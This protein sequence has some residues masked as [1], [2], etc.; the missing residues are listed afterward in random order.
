M[1]RHL[2]NLA[3]IGSLVLCLAMAALTARSCFT[4]D[5]LHWGTLSPSSVSGPCD[6]FISVDGLF[7]FNHLELSIGGQ[8]RLSADW[9]RSHGD[10]SFL[11]SFLAVLYNDP[12]PFIGFGGSLSEWHNG[13]CVVF[14]Q[15]LVF[16]AFAILPFFRQLGLLRQRRNRMHGR[17]PACGYDLRATPDRCP[18]CGRVQSKPPLQPSL[19]RLG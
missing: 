7:V 10:A 11:F 1:T 14:P 13:G 2:S 16:I 6:E 8:H 4:G 18:E 17:C 3:G 12:K 15:L 9:A 19:D 5:I